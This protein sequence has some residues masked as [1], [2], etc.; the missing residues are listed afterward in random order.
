MLSLS[1]YELLKTR[2]SL[3]YKNFNHWYLPVVFYWNK[4][5]HFFMI[6]NPCRIQ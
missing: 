3:T 4:A 5:W 6:A 1:S 2:P